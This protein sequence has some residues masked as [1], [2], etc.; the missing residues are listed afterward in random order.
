MLFQSLQECSLGSNTL[1]CVRTV[2]HVRIQCHVARSLVHVR[3]TINTTRA[4]LAGES[5]PP[6]VAKCGG[7]RLTDLARVLLL[8]SIHT[9]YYFF[10]AVHF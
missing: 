8:D 2:V 10:V 9:I 1:L 7:L 4:R 3:N 6:V 5:Q